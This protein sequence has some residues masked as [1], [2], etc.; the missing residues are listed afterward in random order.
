MNKPA[1]TLSLAMARTDEDFSPE[2]G[3]VDA[4]ADDAAAEIAKSPAPSRIKL[5]RDWTEKQLADLASQEKRLQT[6]LAA[7]DA[8]FENK[9]AEAASERD[10]IKATAT[11]DLKQVTA[12]RAATTVF[13][14]ELTKAEL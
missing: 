9:M 5:A 4:A 13:Q 1:R 3:V 7:A 11:A 2:A 14:G 10:E 6:K 8:A 12:L